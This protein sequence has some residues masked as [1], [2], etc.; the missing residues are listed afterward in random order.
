MADLNRTNI[1]RNLK[2][3]EGLKVQLL[4]VVAELFAGLYKGAEEQVIDALSAA[5]VIMFSIANRVGI[6]LRRLDMA[7]EEKL[8]DRVKNPGNSLREFE[9]EFLEFWRG[10]S[11]AR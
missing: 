3:I 10:K 2:I 1:A 5:V 11:G 8:A 6:S 4:T 9:K 7:I